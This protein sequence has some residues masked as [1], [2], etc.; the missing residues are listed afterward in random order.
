MVDEW[1]DPAG[2]VVEAIHSIVTSPEFA[3]LP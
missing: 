1:Q 3:V 2:R